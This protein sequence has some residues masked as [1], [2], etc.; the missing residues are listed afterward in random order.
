MQ[1]YSSMSDEEKA[2]LGVTQDTTNKI[3]Q[4]YKTQ[5]SVQNTLAA[6]L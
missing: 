2:V 1:A 3:M 6:Y 4:S 5:Q